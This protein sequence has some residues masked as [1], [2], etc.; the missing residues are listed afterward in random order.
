MCSP[1]QVSVLVGDLADR[2]SCLSYVLIPAQERDASGSIDPSADGDRDLWRDRQVPGPFL[3]RDRA[4]QPMGICSLDIVPMN[5]KT[6]QCR[7]VGTREPFPPF[8][9][10]SLPE[11]AGGRRGS[12]H[13]GRDGSNRPSNEILHDGKAK[14]GPGRAVVLFRPQ[15]SCTKCGERS[16]GNEII[17]KWIKA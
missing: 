10:P 17:S 16:A 5:V 13:S 4:P 9:R 6:V 2:P 7:S 8:K 3:V 15:K 12:N 1:R 11:A 14:K